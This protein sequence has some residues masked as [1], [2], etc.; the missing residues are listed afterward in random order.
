MIQLTLIRPL[1]VE[2]GAF[3]FRLPMNYFPKM[4]KVKL[5]DNEQAFADEPQIPFNFRCHIK[6]KDN[7]RQICYPKGF[8]KIENAMNS[9]II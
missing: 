6:T 3:E 4:K 9:V 7:L 1:D 2:S 5:R 8:E